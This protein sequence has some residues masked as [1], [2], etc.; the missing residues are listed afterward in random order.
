VSSTV[1]KSQLSADTLV[2]PLS[3]SSDQLRSTICS[4]CQK[5][6]YDEAIERGQRFPWPL[7]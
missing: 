5:S 7:C 2:A 6:I 3:W 1:R 4:W